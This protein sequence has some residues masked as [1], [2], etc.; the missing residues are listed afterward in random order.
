[1]TEMFYDFASGAVALAIFALILVAMEVGF[2]LGKRIQARTSAASKA[3]IDSTQSSL[4]GVLALI[5]AFTFSIALDR[6]NSRSLALISEANAIGTAYLRS[7]LLPDALRV[8]AQQL[9]EDYADARARMTM[10]NWRQKEERGAL[11]AEALRLQDRLWTQA[12]DISRL[13][14]SPATTGL[15]VQSLNE[16]IDANSSYAAEID[17][18]VPELVLLLLF[19]AF[20]VSGGVMGYSAG[21]GGYRPPRATYVMVFL[22]VLLM[23]VIMDL[24]RPRRG[25]IRLDTRS[26]LDVKALIDQGST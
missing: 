6:F 17:R 9:F 4:T 14:P 10:L 26:L 20:V 15:Y 3:Q 13:A 7:S 19:G 8:E 18:H 5:L 25:I 16:M 12:A 2:R 1:M 23:F 22:V 11:N 21:V 24:D